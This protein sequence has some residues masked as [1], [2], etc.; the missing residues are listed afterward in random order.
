MQNINGRTENTGFG[1]GSDSDKIKIENKFV[2]T[3]AER[4]IDVLKLEYAK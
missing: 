2:V 4:D 1:I 3:H